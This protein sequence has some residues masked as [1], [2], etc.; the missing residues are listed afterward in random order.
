VSL[1]LWIRGSPS[2]MLMYTTKKEE[3]KIDVGD[4]L[5]VWTVSSWWKRTSILVTR[6]EQEQNG[7]EYCKDH[8][9][10]SWSQ[11]GEWPDIL[12]WLPPASHVKLFVRS[13]NWAIHAVQCVPPARATTAFP[14]LRNCTVPWNPDLHKQSILLQVLQPSTAASLICTRRWWSCQEACLHSRL[15]IF[16]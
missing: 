16:H 8:K 3:E 1:L 12:H 14:F 6:Q 10:F 5:E 15:P 11:C 9:Q 7:L 13:S 4:Y 2:L